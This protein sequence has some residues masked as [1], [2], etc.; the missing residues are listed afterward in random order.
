MHDL[1]TTMQEEQKT[2]VILESD[3]LLQI[4]ACNYLIAKYY[5]CLWYLLIAFLVCWTQHQIFH[6]DQ[7]LIYGLNSNSLMCSSFSNL[8]IIHSHLAL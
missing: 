7:F 8:S 1:K 5:T 3:L 4:K 6:H 2:L